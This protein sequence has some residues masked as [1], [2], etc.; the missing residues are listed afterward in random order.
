MNPRDPNV[1]L[2]EAVASALGHLTER[3]VF[4]GGCAVGLMITD[5][6]R[7]I[8]R[9][10]QDVD[11]FVEISTHAAY[12]DLAADLRVAGFNEAQ[13][14]EVICRWRLGSLMVDVMP[15]SEAVFG[16]SNKWSLPA[17]RSAN[18]ISLPSGTRIQLISPPTLI[19]TKL[20]A[21]YNR[22][23]GDYGTSH[24]IEDIVNLV[25]GRA[26]I[27]EEVRQSDNELRTYLAEELDG[28]LGETGFTDVLAWHLGPSQSDQQRVELLIERLRKIAGT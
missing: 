9:A 16:F 11:V 5:S 17:V 10:T 12:Y 8:V 28:L 26:E 15:T 19:A 23:N 14:D 6:G 27:V 20:E 13:T 22:G 3:V 24:D 18:W 25:D 1:L 2:V 7:P 4:V 21:F